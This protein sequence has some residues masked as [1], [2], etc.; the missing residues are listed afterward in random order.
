MTKNFWRWASVL[1]LAVSAYPLVGSLREAPNRPMDVAAGEQ[2]SVPGEI[3]VQLREPLPAD[4]FAADL[5]IGITGET[6]GDSG[7]IL[8]LHADSIGIPSLLIRLRNDA[9]VEYAE[10]Q[11]LFRAYW[12]PN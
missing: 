2:W 3:V 11:H 4:K 5:G 7:R 12:K 6:I 10:P 9:R 1:L 8:D